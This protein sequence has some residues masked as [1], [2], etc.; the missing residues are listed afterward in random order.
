M[1]VRHATEED[2]ARCAEISPIRTAELLT[3]LLGDPD[4]EW[5]VVENDENILR[6]RAAEIASPTLIVQ[7]TE[8][9]VSTRF[10]SEELH[11]AIPDSDLVLLQSDHWVPG[12][13]PDEF[14]AAVL[15]F[16]DRRF[17]PPVAG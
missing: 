3:S 13:R 10:L 8:D 11:A 16:L 2:A 14:N 7:G 6:G 12:L 17:P 1:K 4:V 9:S 5:L 15:G